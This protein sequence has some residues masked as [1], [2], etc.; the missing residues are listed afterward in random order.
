MDLVGNGVVDDVSVSAVGV[1]LV[2]GTL[3]VVAVVL[4]E[5]CGDVVCGSGVL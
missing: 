4:V 5:P 2:N 3:G 1:D